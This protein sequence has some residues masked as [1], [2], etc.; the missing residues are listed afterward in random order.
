MIIASAPFIAGSLEFAWEVEHVLQ[1]GY[2]M[3]EPYFIFAEEVLHFFF[4]KAGTNPIE[5]SPDNV[6]RMQKETS[7]W[8]D[9]EPIA[10]PGE[11]MWQ[12]TEEN[13]THYVSSYF[14]EHYTINLGSIVQ[15]FN[16]SIDGINWEPADPE[17]VI[18]YT[19]GISEVGFAFDLEGNLFGVGRN[20]DG[21]SSGW[22]SR[23]FKADKDSLGK[24]EWYSERSDPYIYE[25]VRMFRH[26]DGKFLLYQSLRLFSR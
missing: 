15:H 21:D 20:E 19:G 6:Y 18:S 3:R 25:S 17:N 8:T 5:F 1:I 26:A 14:G 23:T 12:F 4:F 16:K 9:P 7:G 10:E 2:D 24:W 11:V 22:G 13:G